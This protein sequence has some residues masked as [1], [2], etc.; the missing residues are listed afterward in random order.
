MTA[1]LLVWRHQDSMTEDSTAGVGRLRF[2]IR[3]YDQLTFIALPK[4]TYLDSVQDEKTGFQRI[5]I[6]YALP[7]AVLLWALGTSFLQGLIAIANTTNVYVGVGVGIALFIIIF[8]LLTRTMTLHLHTPRWN[9]M[10]SLGS[11]LCRFRR[12]GDCNVIPCEV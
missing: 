3:T 4:A 7:K 9:L 1:A 8:T 10:G 12:S 5:A 6:I 2:I 11:L